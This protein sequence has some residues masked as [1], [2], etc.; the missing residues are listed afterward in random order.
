MSM[1]VWMP[2]SCVIQEGTLTPGSIRVSK[3][4]TIAPPRRVTVASSITR[5]PAALEPVVSVS[6]M[7]KV[8]S[9]ST[10]LRRVEIQAFLA[11]GVAP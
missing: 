5:A 7:W 8:A 10:A 6:T 11:I 2:V 9:E 3:R 1:R 4:S